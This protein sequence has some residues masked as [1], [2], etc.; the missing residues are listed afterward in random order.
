MQA[1]RWSILAAS[2]EAV[3]TAG[4]AG[5]SL[6]LLPAAHMIVQMINAMNAYPCKAVSD[7]CCQRLFE[8]GNTLRSQNLYRR[9]LSD[10]GAPEAIS[11]G[12]LLFR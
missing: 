4:N 5:G 3:D 11:P 1:H 8:P 10:L 6:L 9:N 7:S 2:R 12:A